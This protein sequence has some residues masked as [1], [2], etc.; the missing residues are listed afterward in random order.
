MEA[1]QTL[2]R[3]NYPED[4]ITKIPKL[5]DFVAPDDRPG[6]IPSDIAQ[7]WDRDPYAYQ[8]E[9]ELMPA[10]GLHGELLTYIA[11][12][13]RVFLETQGLRFLADTFMLYRDSQGI[14]RRIAPDLTIIP[15][16]SPPPSAYDLDIEP[17]PI[18]VIEITSPKSHKKDMKKK[19][20]FYNGLGIAAYLVIDSV[21]SR[22]EPRKQIGL[23]L[24]R[25]VQGRLRKIRPEAHKYLYMPEINMKVKAQA[26]DLTFTNIRTGAILCDTKQMRQQLER[27]TL[28]AE[29]ETLRAE[30]EFLRAEQEKQRAEHL[31]AKLRELGVALE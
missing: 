29:Q 6:W 31:A 13:I 8:T 3:G 25:S 26:R 2:S 23:H 9:E 21:T 11:E 16:R 15:F 1:V 28:R 10:G 14:K 20:T 18:A 30:R 27:E 7:D 12:I 17:A 5:A 22:G 19:V 4:T 24:W